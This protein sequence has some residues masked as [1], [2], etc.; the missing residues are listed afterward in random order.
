MLNFDNINQN[1]PWIITKW[2]KQD[3]L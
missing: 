1:M 2:H 3:Y